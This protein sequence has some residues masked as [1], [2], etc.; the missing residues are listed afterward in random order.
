MF[1]NLP[2]SIFRGI[3]R[4]PL[5]WSLRAVVTAAA[6]GLMVFAGYVRVWEWRQPAMR[7]ERATVSS[8]VPYYRSGGDLHWS[9]R[10]M[11]VYFEGDGETPVAPIDYPAK[12]WD[13]TVQVDDTVDAVIRRS[14]FGNEYDGLQISLRSDESAAAPPG[15]SP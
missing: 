6:L 3:K 14:F 13:E 2:L 9:L 5:A 10:G 8:I 4:R 11:R 1:F 15:A 12:H 7:I